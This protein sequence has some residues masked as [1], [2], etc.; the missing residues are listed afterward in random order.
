MIHVKRLSGRTVEPTPPTSPTTLQYK[1]ASFDVV[2]PHRSL[3]LGSSTFETP[4]EID[5]LLDEYFDRSEHDMASYDHITGEISTPSQQSLGSVGAR[6]RTLYADPDSARR[7]ILGIGG[8]HSAPEIMDVE[9]ES[10]DS[11]DDW[12]DEGKL[13]S[14]HREILCSRI[15]QKSRSVLSTEAV[16]YTHHHSVVISSLYPSATPRME[17]CSTTSQE[18][19]LPTAART[20]LVTL[21]NSTLTP[22]SPCTKT[23]MMRTRMYPALPVP[24]PPRSHTAEPGL[25]KDCE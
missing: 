12:I 16:L 9:D 13:L 19:W 6:Q 17:M 5:G 20:S 8:S 1:G 7:T 18:S 24:P 4:A 25:Q 22:S 14:Q 21:P 2:N 23:V 3:L 10:S 11:N 15:L